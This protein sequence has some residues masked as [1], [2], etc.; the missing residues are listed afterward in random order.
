M[1][2]SVHLKTEEIAINTTAFA[3]YVTEYWVEGNNHQQWNHFDNEGP[4]TNNHLERWHGKLKKHL[5]HAHPNIFFLIDLLQKTQNSTE[6]NQT[7]ISAGGTQRPKLKKYRNIDNRL[8]TLKH[9]FLQAE[10]NKF[11]KKNT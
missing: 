7:Q 3:D 2:G 9:R 10:L 1:Y 11:L 4:H 5:N 6:A 8:T